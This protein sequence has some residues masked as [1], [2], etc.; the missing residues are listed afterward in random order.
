MAVKQGKDALASLEKGGAVADLKWSAP[1]L[2]NRENASNMGRDALNKI[3]Q[4]DM[5]KLPAYAGIENPKGGYTLIKVSKVVESGAI[6]PEKKKAYASQ[7]RQAL[8][9]EYSSA[10]LASLKQKV[11]ISIKLEKLE[12]IEP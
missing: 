11:D 1:I 10:Y 7:L 5:A 12:K 6:D 9:Q 3:F 8:A 4:A 2:I